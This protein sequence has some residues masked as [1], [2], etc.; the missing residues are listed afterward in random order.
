MFTVVDHPVLTVWTDRLRSTGTGTEEFRRLLGQ[1]GQLMVGP[2]TSE[3]PTTLATIETP[4]AK[5][6]GRQLQGGTPVVVSVLRA[7]NGLLDGVLQVLSD[8]DVGFI[9]LV[10][11][12]ETFEAGE[13]LLQLPT[14][15]GRHVLVVDPMLATGN[16]AVAALGRVTTEHPASVT[17][18]CVVAAPE[19]VEH[20]A[21]Q[22]PEVRIVA[23]ALDEGLNELGYI[24]PG[25]GDAGDRLYGTS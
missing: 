18:M 4:L 25:L 13:Y 24:M 16:S 9:G 8:A 21:T 6:T 12:H 23:A 17:L 15:A 20:V 3:L 5:T 22:H 19:G 11:D 7:G 10:R 2:A 1:I 14:L